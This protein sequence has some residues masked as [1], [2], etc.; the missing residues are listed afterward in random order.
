MMPWLPCAD[1]FVSQPVFSITRRHMYRGRGRNQT[2]AR[3]RCSRNLR[4]RLSY[5]PIDIELHERPS[6]LLILTETGDVDSSPF[7]RRTF[8]GPQGKMMRVKADGS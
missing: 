7:V 4:P 6:A 5:L 3:G 8:V 2:L 1:N